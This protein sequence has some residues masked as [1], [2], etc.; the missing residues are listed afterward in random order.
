MAVKVLIVRRGTPKCFE[1][2][3]PLL[4]RLRSLALAQPGYVSGETFLN[5][6]VPGEYL[7]ISTWS[8]LERWTDWLNQPQRAELQ[9]RIDALLG[10]PTLY[11]VYQHV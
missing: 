10:E 1:E 4:Q 6:E 8:S 7:V 5:I 2:L 11:Q 3:K 9:D